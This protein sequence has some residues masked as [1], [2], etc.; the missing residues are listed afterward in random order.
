[1]AHAED[2][3]IKTILAKRRSCGH[4]CLKAMRRTVMCSMVALT[5]PR[6]QLEESL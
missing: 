4:R 2:L 5:V 3:D 1:M 6:D